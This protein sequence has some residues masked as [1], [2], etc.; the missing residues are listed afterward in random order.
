MYPYFIE[1][2]TEDN[3]RMGVNIDCLVYFGDKIIW[4]SDCNGF[5][6]QE[7]YDDIKQ[8]IRDCGCL[9]NKADPRLDTSKPL[10]MEDLKDM[11]GQPVWNSNTGQWML[12]C[13]IDVVAG[14][15]FAVL[16]ESDGIGYD[17][18][19]AKLKAKPMYRMKQ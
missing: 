16:V 9:I 1:V 17:F 4:T 6:V 15:D 10:T 2:H 7:S 19:D 8:L 18:G 5:P 11:I 12:V 13:R 3:L 14:E